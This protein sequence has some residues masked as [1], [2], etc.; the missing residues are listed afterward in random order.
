LEQFLILGIVLSAAQ[1]HAQAQPPYLPDR[2]LV[3]PRL[4]VALAEFSPTARYRGDKIVS[5]HWRASGGALA[6]RVSPWKRLSNGSKPVDWCIM[7]CRIAPDYQLAT[8]NVP[9]DPAY[10]DG[11]LWGLHN[12]GQ[13]GG[14]NDA[15]I[16]A[17][18]G[19]HIRNRAPGIIVAVIDTGVRY[20]HEDLAANMWRNPDDPVDGVDNDNNGFIDDVYGATR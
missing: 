8:H 1:L 10:T 9:N 19:W 12:T 2:I 13:N 15:D 14:L 11:T 16:D 20:T 6:K 7:Q 3:K 18:E 5:V 17:P 4:A